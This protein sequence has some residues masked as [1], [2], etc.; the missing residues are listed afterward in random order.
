[1]TQPEKVGI[2]SERLQ[3]TRPAVEK[4]I[5]NDK[6]AGAVTLLARRGEVVSFE[7]Y[8]ELSRERH[9]PMGNDSIF[10][11]YSMTKPI[12]CVALLQLY[13]HGEFQ[14]RTPVAA[15]IP[16]IADMQ[17]FDGHKLVSQDRPMEIWHL[18]THTSGLTYPGSVEGPVEE[19]Y[20]DR[21][22]LSKIPL[23]DLIAG[24]AETPLVFQPGSR[25]MYGFSQDVAARVVEI[26]SG[27]S[28][29]EYLEENIFSPLD[30]QD[31]GFYVPTEKLDRLCSM[32]GAFNIDNEPDPA[33][34]NKAIDQT[35]N[36]LQADASSDHVSGPHNCFRGGHGLVSTALDYYRFCEMLLQKG[37]YNGGRILGRKTVELMCTNHLPEELLPFDI[38]GMS[39]LGLGYGLGVRVLQDPGAAHVM[40]TKGEFGWGGAASTYFW[41]DPKEELIGIQMAQHQPAGLYPLGS[42]FRTASY[43][44]LID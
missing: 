9:T 35:V 32:Y 30:M 24:L 12:T 36:V 38:G 14:L 22:S 16:R 26:I 5:G 19:A 1:M 27:K 13:E 23:R 42:D 41:I 33:E 39:Q 21:V 4:Y 40:G 31:T 3:R 43:Q 25:Y 34:K 18:M 15:F 8:G 37:A 28:F 29:A 11:I 44:A 10:R 6:V 17:V 2:S 20:R 7:S